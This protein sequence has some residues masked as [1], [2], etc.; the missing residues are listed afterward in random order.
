MEKSRAYIKNE[1]VFRF[2]PVGSAYM[3]RKSQHSMYSSSPLW[4]A[5][6][7]QVGLLKSSQLLQ[8]SKELCISINDSPYL[9]TVKQWNPFR[10]L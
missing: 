4:P 6:E 1:Y 9:N 2:L 8:A 3:M 7:V 10:S 5:S